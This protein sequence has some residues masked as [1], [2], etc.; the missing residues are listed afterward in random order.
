MHDMQT[1]PSVPSSSNS[2]SATVVNE[3]DQ[4]LR[5]GR[6]KWRKAGQSISVVP[7][8]IGTAKD[9]MK[10]EISSLQK[11]VKEFQVTDSQWFNL[12]DK[13]KCLSSEASE[14]FYQEKIKEFAQCYQDGLNAYLRQKPDK[15]FSYLKG[16]EKSNPHYYSFRTEESNEGMLS[17]VVP[18]MPGTFST[19]SQ[20]LGSLLAGHGK[21]GSLAKLLKKSFEPLGLACDTLVGDTWL[22]RLKAAQMPDIA[23]G[24]EPCDTVC[25]EA[26]KPVFSQSGQSMINEEIKLRLIKE[27]RSLYQTNE[28]DFGL[29]RLS[30]QIA[31]LHQCYDPGWQAPAELPDY[32]FY[33]AAKLSDDGLESL[34]NEALLATKRDIFSKNESLKKYVNLLWESFPSLLDDRELVRFNEAF[35]T[36]QIMREAMDILEKPPQRRSEWIKSRL[37]SSRY[38]QENRTRESI[39]QGLLK[40][41]ALGD[42]IRGYPDLAQSVDH[43]AWFM[44]LVGECIRQGMPERL[45]KLGKITVSS[46]FRKI[47]KEQLLQW[48]IERSDKPAY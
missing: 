32:S 19:F 28:S 10:T 18:T 29:C 27:I 25:H 39:Q 7:R 44:N 31:Y 12:L 6:F 1:I 30:Q 40:L 21:S 9:K 17:V 37:F 34:A 48:N 36:T 47:W 26:N 45:F 14:V 35:T 3:T 46:G 42:S 38:E 23:P 16:Y 5:G 33:R 4:K 24:K 22:V 13:H 11:R 15:H 41:Q 8:T 43:S 2:S 20:Q